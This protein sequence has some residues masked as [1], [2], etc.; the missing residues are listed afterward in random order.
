MVE[1]LLPAFDTDI[2][3]SSKRWKS[4]DGTEDSWDMALALFKD[5]VRLMPAKMVCVVDGLHWI[6]DRRTEPY[7]KQLVEALKSTKF[8]VL[9][10]SS[11]RVASLRQCVADEDTLVVENF[12]L[13]SDEELHPMI[14]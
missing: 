12:H 3:L 5:L 6:D 1:H 9:L 7:L 11:G 13:K 8:N 2:D 4:I 10:T 14:E